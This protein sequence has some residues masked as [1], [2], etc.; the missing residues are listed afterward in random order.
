MV[1]LC[2]LA[3]TAHILVVDKYAP[4]ID[5]ILLSCLQFFVSG[6]LSLAVALIIEQPRLDKLYEAW[7]PV[8]YT[9]IMSS[10][11]AYTFQIIGQKR[12]KPAVASLLMS[13]EAV[14]AV[15][16]GWLILRQ[17]LSTRELTGCGLMFAAIVLVQLA[18]AKK[19]KEAEK[20]ENAHAI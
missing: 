9:G 16:A 8:L 11:V 19:T 5:G 13:F 10:S 14:F 1:F 12:L 4:D 15:L 3:F 20:V 6:I 7:L 17:S 2:A 18:P